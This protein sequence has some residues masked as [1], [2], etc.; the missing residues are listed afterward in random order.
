MILI[1][2]GA[3]YIGSHVMIELLT[4]GYD[5]VVLDNFSNSSVTALDRVKVITGR[6]FELVV[7]DVRDRD[8]L[9]QLFESYQI[10]CVI[11][12]AGVKSVFES[13]HAPIKYYS[14][15]F[16]G[17]LHLTDVMQLH[18]VKNI[19][20][21]STATVYGIPEQVP[22]AESAKEGDTQNPY[23][24]SK[25]MVEKLLKDIS[26]SDEAWTVITLRYFNPIGAH[27]SGDIGEDPKGTPDNL[28]PYLTQV[29]VGKQKVLSIFG[30]NYPTLDGTGVRDFIHVTDLAKGHIAALK[31]LHEHQG[32]HVY[33][34]G[35]GQGYSVLQVVEQFEAV[36]GKS[37]PVQFM[38]RREGDVAECYADA[39]KAYK[40]L[41]WRAE[42]ELSEMLVDA[43][44]WQSTNPN[45]YPE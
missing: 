35:T 44:R 25:W 3:G 7:G 45:G 32:F 2:G 24:T 15:N 16:A 5:V 42:K 13:N 20:F 21:S 12:L 43:W 39:G 33:N 19:I 17:T 30:N 1:T 38:G 11:H 37:V 28:L 9:H 31:H 36:I 4:E 41:G 26:T 10:T 6:H 22:I 18:G 8:L 14:N 23:G 27:P 29:G 34:L 40:N